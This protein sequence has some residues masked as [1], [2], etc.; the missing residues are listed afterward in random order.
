MT[1][2]QSA[3][4]VRWQD[5]A[6]CTDAEI[7]FTPAQE[8]AKV[9]LMV[10]T[11]YCNSCQVRA[12]CLAYALVY[13]AQGY[14]GGTSTSD[15]KLLSYPRHRVKCPACKCKSVVSTEI[16]QI[17]QACGLSWTRT[18]AEGPST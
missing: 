9:L 8:T 15:R 1:R 16:H 3:A 17:C 13:K 10:Q 5:K 14:W 4:E 11:V 6:N 7:D 2:M 12:E 18:G